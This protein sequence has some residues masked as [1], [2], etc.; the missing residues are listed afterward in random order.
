MTISPMVGTAQGHFRGV[1]KPAE[2]HGLL[3]F[4]LGLVCVICIST[5]AGCAG[6]PSGNHSYGGKTPVSSK[7]SSVDSAENG[8][9]PSVRVVDFGKDLE[10]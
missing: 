2:K 7:V 5:I 1:G 6:Q 9:P 4:V 8:P 3:C 10:R